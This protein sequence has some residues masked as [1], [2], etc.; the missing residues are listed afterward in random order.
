[1]LNTLVIGEDNDKE[2]LLDI[3]EEVVGDGSRLATNALGWKWIH[4][5]D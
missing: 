2:N 4:I 1:M 3:A 5:K